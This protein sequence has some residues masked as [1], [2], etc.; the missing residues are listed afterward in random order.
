LLTARYSGYAAYARS[1]ASRTPS[2]LFTDSDGFL[3]SINAASGLLQWAWTSRNIVAQLQNYA[4]FP[5]LGMTNGNFT[6]VD[7]MNASNTWGTYVVGSLQSGAEHFSL[8]LDSTASASAGT[9]T[10]VIKD[11]VVTGTSAGDAAGTAGTTP[12]RQPTVVAYVGNVAYHVYVVTSGTT[13]TL[14]ESN[15][16]ASTAPSSASLGFQVSSIISLDA[17]SNQLWLGG[18]DGSVR[19]LRITGDAS[20]DVPSMSTI[21]TVVTPSTGAALPKVL[22]VG[23]VEVGGIPYVYAAN[24]AQITVFGIGSAGWVPLWA[25]TPAQGYTYNQ[26]TSSYVVSSTVT[27]MTSSS[28]ISDLPLQVGSGLLVPTFVAGAATCP[29]TPGS[30]YYDFFDL[31]NGTFPTTNLTYNGTP[32]IADMSIGSGPAFTPSLTAI[33]GGIALSPGSLGNP[34]PPT[35]PLKNLGGLGPRA[36]SWTQH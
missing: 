1:L 10:N 14:Y 15:V 32:V 8:A 30:G 4:S 13:S 31:A 27:T 21:G 26:T 28:V 29:A 9:P 35:S 2:V 19:T 11:T 7:A 3:Y 12:L 34:N 23:Y 33:S 16:A 17:S 5:T 6:V 24:S 25:T 22:Y 18:Q 20:A 36:I